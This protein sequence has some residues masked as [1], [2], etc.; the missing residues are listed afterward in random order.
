MI[1]LTI[2]MS[3]VVLSLQNPLNDPNGSLEYILYWIDVVTTI[4]FTIEAILKNIAYGFA[5]NGK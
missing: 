5:F 3:S 1:L 2:F 4:I